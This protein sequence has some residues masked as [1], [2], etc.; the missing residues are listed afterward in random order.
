MR[1]AITLEELKGTAGE[2]IINKPNHYHKGGIDIYEIMQAKLSKEVYEGF[3][4][5]NVLKYV[6]RHDMKG[7]VQDLKKARFNLDRLIESKEGIKYV[8]EHKKVENYE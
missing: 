4:I 3:C 5:G 7:G 2:D 6:L 8:P 1:K